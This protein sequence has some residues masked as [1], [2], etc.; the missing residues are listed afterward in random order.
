M[1][2][3]E[4]HAGKMPNNPSKK[5]KQ[6]RRAVKRSATSKIDLERNERWVN[7]MKHAI[8]REKALVGSYMDLSRY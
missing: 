8:E 3:K 7:L 6:V 1:N 4:L 2:K 5:R